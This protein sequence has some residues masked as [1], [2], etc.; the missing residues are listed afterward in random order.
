MI[1]TIGATAILA[2]SAL[3]PAEQARAQD[4]LGGAIVG[5]AIGGVIGGAATGRAGGAVAGAIIGGATG[6]IIASEGRRYRGG[7]YWWHGGCY[8][9][10]PNGDF[11]RV[12]RGY[13]Y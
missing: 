11:V 2:L 4:P 6:A 10:Y 12:R 9:R 7:Y 13:C 3:M 8:H 1:R 5:G